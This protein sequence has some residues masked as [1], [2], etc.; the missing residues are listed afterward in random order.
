MAALSPWFDN[1][2]MRAPCR[3]KGLAAAWI[4]VAHAGGPQT[5]APEATEMPASMLLEATLAGAWSLYSLSPSPPCVPGV[6]STSASL[7]SPRGLCRTLCTSLHPGLA[8][9]LQAGIPR[10]RSVASERAVGVHEALQALTACKM[11]R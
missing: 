1:K 2:W 3:T 5:A 11:M 6:T 10:R 7:P 4:E 9:R 8:C